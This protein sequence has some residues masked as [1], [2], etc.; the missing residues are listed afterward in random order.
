M[1]DI[2]I[3]EKQNHDI[4]NGTKLFIKA[5]GMVRSTEDFLRTAVRKIMN[6]FGRTDLAPA[7][8]IILKELTMNA[9]KANFKKVFFLENRLNIDN[10]VDYAEGMNQFRDTMSETMFFDYGRKARAAN[11][12]VIIS[13][14]Y[15]QDRVVI[16][17]R[18][19]VPMSPD[20]ERRAREKLRT[21]MASTD[22]T[23]LFVDNIDESEGAGLGLMLCLTTL[24]SSSIDP[25]MLSIATDF[26]K[27][28]VAR[29]EIPLHGAYVPAR[30]RWQKSL[31]V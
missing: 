28:T 15:D 4:E 11:L 8:E 16:E 22:L 30:A 5:Y 12:N 7:V 26:E 20:E 29:V 9:A 24:R 19:N 13:M 1:L 6:R 31:A 3:T 17:V 27:E 2:E 21:A 23:Q 10:P 18:N 25:R 14:D